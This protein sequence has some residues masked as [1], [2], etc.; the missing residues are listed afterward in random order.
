MA[1][2][3]RRFLALVLT[4][5]LAFSLLPI[6]GVAEAENDADSGTVVTNGKVVNSS[7][8]KVSIQKTAVKTAKNT[9]DITLSVTTA[10]DVQTT[11][12]G[13]SAHVVLVID[14]SGS[15]S[16][17]RIAN[18]KSAAN[19][20][21]DAFFGEGS[22]ENNRVAVVS[23][24]TTESSDIGLSA[25]DSAASVKSVINGLSADGGTN[26]QGALA[27]AQ[28]ILT[29]GHVNG[30]KDIIVLLSD[31][32][33]TY[34]YKGTAYTTENANLPSVTRKWH[35]GG[36]FSDG[37]YSYNTTG[38]YAFRITSFGSSVVG[39]GNSWIGNDAEYRIG[40]TYVDGHREG[41][42]WINGHYEGGVE[43]VDSVL[44]TL[45]Q[46]YLDK[47]AGTEIYSIL[48]MSP[49]EGSYTV[50]NH[51]MSNTASDA[52]HYKTTAD[53]AN[54]GGI[55]KTISSSITTPTNSGMVN[56][57]MGADISY[58]GLKN[59]ADAN[60][61]T[62][63][64]NTNILTWD[65]AKTNAA[66][67][68]NGT[69][70]RTLTYTVMLD[71]AAQGFAENTEYPT[72]GTTTFKYTIG[73]STT[74]NTLDFDVPT[75]SGII[76]ERGYTIEYYKWDKTT[77]GYVLQTSDT[78]NN[79]AA[80][81]WTKI[82]APEGYA[83][84]Y[85][86]FNFDH[87]S[88][89]ITVE[90]SEVPGMVISTGENIL[91]LYYNQIATDVEVINHY[92]TL[93][94]N[95][96]QSVSVAETSSS[97]V[98]TG[99]VGDSYTAVPTAA[100]NN[101][102]FAYF[103]NKTV[104]GTS[105]TS[106]NLSIDSLA[107]NATAG[108]HS[109]VINIYYSKDVDARTDVDYTVNH[110]Y[111]DK[112]YVLNA[113]GKYELKDTVT[114]GTPDTGTGKNGTQITAA[115]K[116]D[117]GYTVKSYDPSAKITLDKSGNNTIMVV[118][119]KIATR[120]AST[121]YV[122]NRYYST[123]SVSQ[124]GNNTNYITT[125]TVNGAALDGY[126]GETYTASES[127]YT[128][129]N[130]NTYTPVSG[131]VTSVTLKAA[132]KDNVIDLYYERDARQ[133]ATVVVNHTR[134][135]YEETVGTDGKA[136]Y[137]LKSTDTTGSGTLQ[138]TFYVGQ[139]FTATPDARSYTQI[140]AD[141]SNYQNVKLTAG[142]NTFN[143][144]Y[145]SK[146]SSLGAADVTVVHHYR[147]YVTYVN[148]T[149]GDV[150]SNELSSN[151]NKTYDVSDA[152]V[153]G[154]VGE[155]F[156]ATAKAVTGYTKS[157]PDDMKVTLTGPNG[158][159]DIYYDAYENLLVNTNVT[160]IRHYGT[161]TT[162][163]AADGS[164]VRGTWTEDQ[165]AK[166]TVYGNGL[167]KYYVGQFFTANPG[168]YSDYSGYVFDNVKQGTAA[169][170]NV[171]LAN[172]GNVINLYYS[173]EA[174]SR[175]PA[176]VIVRDHY[177]TT[178][179]YIENGVVKTRVETN[180]V[181]RDPAAKYVGERYTAEA[182]SADFTVNGAASQT[183][184]VAKTDVTV[185][186]NHNVNYI[187]FNYSKSVNLAQ[188]TIT[189]THVYKV[190]DQNGAEL[191]DRESTITDQPVTTNAGVWFTPTLATLNDAYKVVGA[192]NSNN[193]TWHDNATYTM[194]LQPGANT[195]TITYKQTIETRQ[196]TSVT[197]NHVYKTYDKYTNVTTD[198]TELN[199]SDVFST[200]RDASG[201]ITNGIYVGASYT[202]APD[203][204]KDTGYAVQTSEA[205]RT[206]K[207][208]A[209]TGN[210]IT[211]TYLKTVDSNPGTPVYPP[212]TPPVVIPDPETPKTDVPETPTPT[213]P[214]TDITEPD[215]PKADA[216][217]QVTGDE[218]VLW[219]ALALASA[220]ALVY[221]IIIDVRRRNG[222]ER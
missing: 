9:F 160:V 201:F 38:T 10:D 45:S 87:A 178:T 61:A 90:G 207:S 28:T 184:S 165:S 176:S 15:M 24:S 51:V 6:G 36:W 22:S 162:S 48:L 11:T 161:Y 67:N 182:N 70:T 77:N 202:A 121:T 173:K 130:G 131:N 177:T 35:E 53:A 98:V 50:A 25:K 152:K 126:V 79:N 4:L 20:F 153:E 37:Y 21:V 49:S 217:T 106:D 115:A 5:V 56:D 27:A 187:D 75:V 65:S 114:Y 55:F 78:I 156:T 60:A 47:Q 26:I 73:T 31:G 116:T 3:S 12:S 16:G 119:E 1:K 155:F 88:S 59:S 104:N 111:H 175:V 181:T 124:D 14:R 189:V 133:I 93:T 220:T 214:G 148:S 44:P 64:Q 129:Y 118:Y 174:D 149:T 222:D 141:P 101:G 40:S 208:L 188:A 132:A 172:E 164:T 117:G 34:S 68:S 42:R 30:V 62:Y 97:T 84:K 54:L 134:N 167:E 69:K 143:F 205:D 135:L 192:E 196:A 150:V 83:D 2:K 209:Q 102:G 221:I 154:K 33:P 216:G 120:P 112:T 74:E 46:A 197:V 140:S 81:V 198:N 163:I 168:N 110:E 219:I 158:Q 80:D 17:T 204:P 199:H 146:Q 157:S 203:T 195:I 194:E 179:Q 180:D 108:T 66:T 139:L 86:N 19:Q 13:E 137:T 82:Q 213:D 71:T 218:L 125:E 210:V 105:Y 170:Q 186:S 190:Y 103:S 89:T 183:I 52:A 123:T 76:P 94:T 166:E 193:N 43:V 144:V 136:T 107:A 58:V 109:N 23:Y 159:F 215:T 212:Y 113:S 99:Y 100:D 200:A 142:T 57:P 171:K 122:I 39:E 92:L 128:T 206:I 211:I 63:D 85:A 95:D 185:G 72:N 18:A 29:N 8:G 145:E 7:D 127:D 138:G 169:Y 41:F 147:T 191:K 96:D 151:A 32:E 91:R